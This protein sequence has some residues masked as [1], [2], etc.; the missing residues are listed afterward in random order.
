MLCYPSGFSDGFQSAGVIHLNRFPQRISF[1][2]L[3]LEVDNFDQW[4]RCLASQPNFIASFPE[5][6]QAECWAIC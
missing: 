5:T 4:L 2:C 3:Q 6:F 1:H